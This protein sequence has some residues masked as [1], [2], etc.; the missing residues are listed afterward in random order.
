MTIQYR[1]LETIDDLENVVDLEMLVWELPA[2]EATPSGLLHAMVN[3]GSLVVGAYDGDKLIGMALMFPTAR[4]N[5]KLLWSH[6]AAVHPDYQSRGIGFDIKQFQRKWALENGYLEIG[7]TFD[8]LQRGNANFNLHVLG[9]SANIY[10]E[11]FY[12]ELNDGINAGLPSDRVE[13]LWKLNS[14]RVKRLGERKQSPSLFRVPDHIDDEIYLLRSVDNQPVT[15]EFSTQRSFY[16]VEI[17]SKISAL[18]ETSKD[19][20]LAWRIA[21][22]NTF[23]NAFRAGYMAQDFVTLNSRH[24]YVLVAKQ[25]WYMY[26]LECS[27]QSLYTGITPDLSQRVMKH[28]KGNGAA[29]TKTRRPVILIAAWQ[30]SD[31]QAAMKAEIAFKRLHRD[32]KL[33]F[34]KNRQ[35]FNN[36]P[37]VDIGV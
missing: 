37:F 27:D 35:N 26:V 32:K 25:A 14:Q 19:L 3:T 5:K 22:R 28:N 20:A 36:A 29:Y 13:V 30:F 33:N 16:L 7:W 1:S 23:Q 31:R 34:I 17:P 4:S 24:Y 12:G 21:L 18:K 9:G 11:N 2:R 6:M 15:L 8:P 10:H